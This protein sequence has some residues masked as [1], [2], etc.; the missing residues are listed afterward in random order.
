MS[1]AAHQEDTPSPTKDAE[2][3]ERAEA[4]PSAKG[5]DKKKPPCPFCVEAFGDVPLPGNSLL[6]VIDGLNDSVQRDSYIEHLVNYH[7]V[8]WERYSVLAGARRQPLPTHAPVSR[9]RKRVIS[10]ASKYKEISD[11]KLGYVLI[12]P[13]GDDEHVPAAVMGIQTDALEAIR[14][15]ASGP[16]GTYH[17]QATTAAIISAQ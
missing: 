6:C 16:I 1:L 8:D 9:V 4:P 3:A 14:V 15:S 7:R 11:P 10:K 12:P 13:D 2:W 17:S 5:A